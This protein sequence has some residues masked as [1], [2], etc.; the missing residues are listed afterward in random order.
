MAKLC[1]RE[2]ILFP[3]LHKIKELHWN[4]ED[5][6]VARGITYCLLQNGVLDIAGNVYEPKKEAVLELLKFHGG[7]NSIVAVPMSKLATE[8]G[9][10][11]KVVNRLIRELEAEGSIRRFKRRAPGRLYVMEIVSSAPEPKCDQLLPVDMALL[12]L[13]SRRDDD[14]IQT[15]EHELASKLGVSQETVFLCLMH[16]KRCGYISSARALYGRPLVIKVHRQL[17]GDFDSKKKLARFLKWRRSMRQ[18]EEEETKV[19]AREFGISE[20][21][22]V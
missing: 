1:D 7:S 10:G 13:L 6:E 12:D 9:C 22:H 2:G 3:G 8:L 4:G 16:L 17:Q 19:L 21:A 14:I 15:N 18:E 11:V 5:Y 20:V